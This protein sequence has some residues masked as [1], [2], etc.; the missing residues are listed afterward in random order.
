MG[1]TPAIPVLGRRMSE[2]KSSSLLLI[3]Y[4]SEAIIGFKRPIS[5]KEKELSWLVCR[6]RDPFLSLINLLNLQKAFFIAAPM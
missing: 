5:K 2:S 6:P 1:Y 4:E 3:K